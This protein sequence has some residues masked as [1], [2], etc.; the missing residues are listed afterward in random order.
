MGWGFIFFK[1]H[2]KEK[3]FYSKNSVWL[4]LIKIF[5]HRMNS[6]RRA[7]VLF[8][9]IEHR[10]SKP[11]GNS[12]LPHMMMREP[13]HNLPSASLLGEKADIRTRPRK[14]RKTPVV[15]PE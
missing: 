10:L 2:L 3:A 4:H 11:A 6:A 8:N 9:L 1:H 14:H 7:K 12:L 5:R 15:A 13:P